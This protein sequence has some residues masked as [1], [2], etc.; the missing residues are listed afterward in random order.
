MGGVGS[1]M[2]SVWPELSVVSSAR[3]APSAGSVTRTRAPWMG[4]GSSPTVTTTCR[5]PLP[6]YAGFITASLLS[7]Y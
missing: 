3:T 5:V 2:V 6:M 7:V 4:D 1:S